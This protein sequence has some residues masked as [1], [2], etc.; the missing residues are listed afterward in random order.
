MMYFLRRGADMEI[1]GSMGLTPLH[2]CVFM[3]VLPMPASMVWRCRFRGLARPT[4]ARATARSLLIHAQASLS[5]SISLCL[6][7]AMQVDPR[8]TVLDFSA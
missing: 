1:T 3:L 2:V 8:L 4:G 5:L 7:M 6:S